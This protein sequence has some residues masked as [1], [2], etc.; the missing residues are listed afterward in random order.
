M[1][2]V[3]K[4]LKKIPHDL[5]FIHPQIKIHHGLSVANDEK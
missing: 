2:T 3:K 1:P 4:C 5:D